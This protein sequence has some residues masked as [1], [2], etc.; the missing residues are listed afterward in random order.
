MSEATRRKVKELDPYL[1]GRIGE[2]LIQLEQLK[3][4]SN[5]SGTSRVYYTGNWAKDVYDNFTDKQAQTIFGK[6]T[7]L[8]EGLS[9]Y[10]VKL[11]PFT[12]E[13]GQEWVGYDYVARK[14]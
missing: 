10:Q 4:P 8:K 13:E 14:I 6:V 2:A 11:E 1:K 5:L 9:L 7:K 12:D 3:K